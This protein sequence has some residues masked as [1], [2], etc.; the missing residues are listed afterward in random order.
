MAIIAR[1]SAMIRHCAPSANANTPGESAER[2]ARISWH[3]TSTPVSRRFVRSRSRQ[4]RATAAGRRTPRWMPPERS[5]SGREAIAE[6]AIC[7]ECRDRAWRQTVG[8]HESA[9]SQPLPPNRT[10]DSCWRAL[11]RTAR[12]NAG[13]RQVRAR[14]E[15]HV[16]VAMGPRP[17]RAAGRW[18][19]ISCG[20]SR[21]LSPRRG[22]RGDA[23]NGPSWSS[24]RLGA[25]S[26]LACWRSTTA[27]KRHSLS[28]AGSASRCVTT[29]RS[30]SSVSVKC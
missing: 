11:H 22:R 1:P 9:P 16:G 13:L 7:A 8:A 5:P 29:Q 26:V 6:P 14:P 4:R 23:Q 15:R 17:R 21:W 27:T 3:L 20:L 28:L 24:L 12:P 25:P 10:L 18:Y 2:A 19:G 30:A